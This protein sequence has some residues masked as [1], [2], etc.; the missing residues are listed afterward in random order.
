MMKTIVDANSNLTKCANTSSSTS[1][2]P[3][4]CSII[5]NSSWVLGAQVCVAKGFRRKGILRRLYDAQV[6]QMAILGFPVVVT[7]VDK[8]NVPSLRAHEKAGFEVLETFPTGGR[9]N[10]GWY[11]IGRQNWRSLPM[12]DRDTKVAKSNN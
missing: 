5:A 12:T 10:T 11:I 6:E 4:L 1:T 2:T 3:S 7:A 8:A 9:D